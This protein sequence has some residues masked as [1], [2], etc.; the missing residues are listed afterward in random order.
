MTEECA[1]RRPIPRWVRALAW[2]NLAVAPV[3]AALGLAYQTLE[4]AVG[5]LALAA[6]G[7]V[8]LT[9]R[10]PGPPA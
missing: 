7:V 2:F 1:D 5:G 6:L 4:W 3:F 10:Q 9:R 8:Q